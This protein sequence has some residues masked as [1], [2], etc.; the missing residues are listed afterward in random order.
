MHDCKRHHY[1][2]DPLFFGKCKCG[3]LLTSR[4]T[5]RLLWN[6]I[7]GRS[8]AKSVLCIDGVRIRAKKRRLAAR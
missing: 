6:M 1:I 3:C 5:R 4:N 2:V 8:R 7:A